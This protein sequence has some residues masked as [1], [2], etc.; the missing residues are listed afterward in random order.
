MVVTRPLVRHLAAVQ[1][2]G[3]KP[4]L[5]QIKSPLKTVIS[6]CTWAQLRLLVPAST[7][8][9]TLYGC[10]LT[11]GELVRPVGMEKWNPLIV[12]VRHLTP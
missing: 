5:D 10:R 6:Q 1:S 12:S 2:S 3:P 11:S 8:T 9:K 7:G 4:G